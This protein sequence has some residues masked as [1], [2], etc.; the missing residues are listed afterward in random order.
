MVKGGE[1]CSNEC[2][3]ITGINIYNPNFLKEFV[4]PTPEHSCSSGQQSCSGISLKDR[5]YPQS[6]AFKNQQVNL[7]LST[8]TMIYLDH[9]YCRVP[10]KQVECQRRLGVQECNSLIRLE[11]SLESLYGMEAR[12]KQFS[13]RCNAVGLEQNVRFCI[14]TFQL[15]RL[16]DKQGFPEKRKSND[17]SDTHMRDTTLV[18]SPTKNVHTTSIAFTSPTKPITKSPGRKTSSSENQVPKV[19]GVENYMRTLEMEGISCNQ[20]NLSPC[21]G[22]QVQLQVT[23]RP[24]TSG[25]AGVVDYKLIQFVRQW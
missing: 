14:S 20:P 17:T 4:T 25:V 16:G 7:D 18:Y 11:T 22:D 5:W 9:N 10:F 3:R 13:N 2:S 24:E 15:D 21:P 12:S 6:T 19:T 23:N 1:T 8:I